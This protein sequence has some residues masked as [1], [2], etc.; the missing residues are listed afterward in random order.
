MSSTHL[1][2][3]YE[4]REALDK[5]MI[6]LLNEE[7]EKLKKE[8]RNTYYKLKEENDELKFELYRLACKF[9]KHRHCELSE[10]DSESESD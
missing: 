10:S 7:N 2:N 8:H 9:A 4:K 3:L 1:S 6:K 5:E